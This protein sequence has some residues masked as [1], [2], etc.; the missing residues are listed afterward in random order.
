MQL[1]VS[2]VIQQTSSAA[3]DSPD[4]L[5][6]QM[7]IY[8]SESLCVGNYVDYSVPVFPLQL[9]I[10]SQ[11]QCIYKGTVP[12]LIPYLKNLGLHCPTYHNPADFS[13]SPFFSWSKF[14]CI[15]SLFVFKMLSNCPQSLRWRQG[16][17]EIWTQCCSRRS[18]VDCAQR[19]VRRTPGTKVTLH[20][21][22]S[23]TVWVLTTQLQVI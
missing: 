14:M 2:R 20:V 16:S 23:V 5:V 7:F 19:R 8:Y 6:Y 11:G 15:W 17:M 4:L 13:K 12:Y 10:L 1:S 3:V 22:P 9:Y 18:R 21:P